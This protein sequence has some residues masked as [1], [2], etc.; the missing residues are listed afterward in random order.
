MAKM[1]GDIY[2]SDDA[3][4]IMVAT[5]ARLFVWADPQTHS[6]I[7]VIVNQPKPAEVET[8]SI[9]LYRLDSVKFAETLKVMIKGA[10][11]NSPFIEADP[12]QNAIRV[13]GTADEVSEVRMIIRILDDNP[14]G[15]GGNMRII[16]LEKGSGA[17]VGEALFLLGP[18]FAKA[19]N[20]S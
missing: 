8:V 4:K 13:R 5:P 18:R 19:T 12:D 6:E 10:K 14:Q 16:N 1:L 17:T 3:I 2:K 11:E 7:N 15:T 9:T 20:G